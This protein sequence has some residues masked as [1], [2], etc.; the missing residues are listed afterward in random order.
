MFYLYKASKYDIC[1]VGRSMIEMLG[2]LAIIAVLSVGG[3]AGYSKAM[4]MYK[5]NK[6]KSGM[7]ELIGGFLQIKDELGYTKGGYTQG[8]AKIFKDLDMIPAGFSADVVY[9]NTYGD[10]YCKKNLKCLKNL[11]RDDIQ[12]LCYAYKDK[13]PK[14]YQFAIQMVFKL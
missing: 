2:V 14:K 8:Y 6:Y 5:I 12:E 11:T 1:C 10:N 4:D 7:Y 9:F 13:D 3:I